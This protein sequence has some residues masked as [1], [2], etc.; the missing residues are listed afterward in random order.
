MR[1]EPVPATS[2][3]ARVLVALYV[4]EIAATLPD[5]F[6]PAASVSADPGELSPPHGVFL[7]VRAEDGNA[8]GCGGVKLLDPATAEVKRMWLDPAARG[9]GSGR[10]LL[11]ALEDAAR[12]LGAT[13]AC[14]DT[15]GVLTAAIDL[16]RKAG[17]QQVE[18]YND[19]RYATHWFSK[20]L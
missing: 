13:T 10:A 2:V 8:V 7:V 3:E 17:W 9:Q 4:A 12:E 14:L 6:D 1:I 15:N 20:A 18:A 19:N 16:Y 5:G 11:A